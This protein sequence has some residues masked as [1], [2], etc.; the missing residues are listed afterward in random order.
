MIKSELDRQGRKVSWFS[1]Q[2]GKSKSATF[3][4]FNRASI[5][6]GELERIS[7]VLDFDFFKVFSDNFS[8]E[9]QD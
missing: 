8:L 5:D 7:K 6:T 2:I 1:E 3:A 9:N 4:L